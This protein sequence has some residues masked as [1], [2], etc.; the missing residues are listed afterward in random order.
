MCV[1]C[2]WD[3]VW[4]CACAEKLQQRP[5]SLAEGGRPRFHSCASSHAKHSRD[6]PNGLDPGVAGG[7]GLLFRT[8][9]HLSD[10]NPGFDIQHIMTFKVGV[11]HSLT[12]T[13]PS[14]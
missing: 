1:D 7:R 12:K 6:R 8:L 4:P 3:S 9:R 10:V 5:A 2:C 13:A 14:T 11:S